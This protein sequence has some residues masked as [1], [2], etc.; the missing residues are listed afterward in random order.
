MGSIM[1]ACHR[2]CESSV[3]ATV[4]SNQV[5]L[6]QFSCSMHVQHQRFESRRTCGRSILNRPARDGQLEAD[7][8]K[9]IFSAHACPFP[10]SPTEL[11]Q[12]RAF[13][14]SR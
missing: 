13:E 4:L 3:T 1:R 5:P 2:C 9:A 10:S 6:K 8:P 12:N 14:P 11:V 7:V